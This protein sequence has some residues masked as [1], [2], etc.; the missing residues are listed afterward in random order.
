MSLS[1]AC[2]GVYVSDTKEGENHFILAS[3]ATVV[4]ELFCDFFL[5]SFLQDL[6]SFCGVA[7]AAVVGWK[8]EI[9]ARICFLHSCLSLPPFHSKTR[10]IKSP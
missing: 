1:L 5:P 4:Y 2:V 6:S 10:V 8:R 9:F 7:V 3:L